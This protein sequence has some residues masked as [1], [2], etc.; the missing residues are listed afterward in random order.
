MLFLLS[1]PHFPLT[2]TELIAFSSAPHAF[3]CVC[4]D[5]QMNVCVST[6][7][8][9][10][11]CVFNMPI[12][13]DLSRIGIPALLSLHFRN[14]IVAISQ[15]QMTVSYQR[16]GENNNVDLVQYYFFFV[17]LLKQLRNNTKVINQT[18]MLGVTCNTSHDIIFTS[19]PLLVF[20]AHRDMPNFGGIRRT[21]S[22]RHLYVREAENC[23]FAFFYISSHVSTQKCLFPL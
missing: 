11:V 21:H 16:M 6:W 22:V 8:I 15:P 14:R 7:H 18:R 13:Q 2:S 1:N 4:M 10:C 17:L 5:V 12:T 23:E 9:V 20:V 19:S 3:I